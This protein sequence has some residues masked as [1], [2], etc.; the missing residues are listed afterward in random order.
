MAEA[1]QGREVL[2]EQTYGGKL[3]PKDYKNPTAVVRKK[4]SPQKV[5]M[6]IGKVLVLLYCIMYAFCLIC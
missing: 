6:I 3:P 4:V 5:A 2:A 1:I